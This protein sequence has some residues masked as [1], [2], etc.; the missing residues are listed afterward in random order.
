MM[1]TPKLHSYYESQ[2]HM[3][4][5]IRSNVDVQM[6]VNAAALSQLNYKRNKEAREAYHILYPLLKPHHPCY[7]SSY[8][9]AVGILH[10]DIFP[11]SVAKFVEM[12]GSD[13]KYLLEFYGLNDLGDSVS[14][15]PD[16][17]SSGSFLFEAAPNKETNVGRYRCLQILANH[18]GL[19]LDLVKYPG[20]DIFR[21]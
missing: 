11:K 1:P 14:I 16:T 9:E 7:P 18:I 21:G 10:P 5:T 19:K 3:E 4:S 8:S 20:L 6:A 13:V 17:G 12:T 2:F 15:P